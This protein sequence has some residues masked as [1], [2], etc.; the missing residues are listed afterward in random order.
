MVGHHSLTTAANR[1][2]LLHIAPYLMTARCGWA[3]NATGRAT[4]AVLAQAMATM[5]P[6]AAA[7]EEW[8]KRCAGAGGT[9]QLCGERPIPR[10]QHTAGGECAL[11]DALHAGFESLCK[12]LGR[13]ERGQQRRRRCRGGAVARVGL[14][15]LGRRIAAGQRSLA[16]AEIPGVLVSPPDRAWHHTH[17]A[18][19]SR[20][21]GRRGGGLPAVL[22]R[23]RHHRPRHKLLRMRM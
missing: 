6:C 23:A 10:A 11:E 17:P 19:P 1:S 5:A 18:A 3:A 7:C 20:S 9:Q 12:S 15:P 4:A 14:D 16:A 8:L 22:R 2:S 21:H 13:W